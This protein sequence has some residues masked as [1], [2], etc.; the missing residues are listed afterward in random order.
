MAD[1][2]IPDD[3]RQF[4]LQRIGS[5]AE[6]EALLLARREPEPAW[7][8]SRVAERLYIEEA[9][10]REILERLTTEGLLTASAENYRCMTES[11]GQC[12]LID[13]VAE[14]YARNLIPVTNLVHTKPSA[15]QAFANAFRLRKDR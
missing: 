5:I 8:A 12:E 9:A 7:T 10:A 1:Q 11:A 6:L 13:K 14:L 3:V 2:L 15:I 4:I